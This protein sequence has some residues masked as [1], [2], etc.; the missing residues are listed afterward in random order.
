[1]L[2]DAMY[3]VLFAPFLFARLY[4]SSGSASLRR[5]L[6][7]KHAADGVNARVGGTLSVLHKASL[8]VS[9]S[10]AATSLL[11][12]TLVACVEPT[13]AG[14]FRLRSDRH[15]FFSSALAGRHRS[16]RAPAV[17]AQDRHTN[18]TF[19]P[20]ASYTS[21]MHRLQFPERRSA[22]KFCTFARLSPSVSSSTD[23]ARRVRVMIV[24]DDR[25]RNRPGH[26]RDS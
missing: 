6:F 12:K 21:W 5:Q 25:V 17:P 1:M 3:R 8:P 2:I 18:E 20:I 24:V 22:F 11:M 19:A 10:I 16:M 14:R 4:S 9:K 7:M 15:F 13:E 26:Q 23:L